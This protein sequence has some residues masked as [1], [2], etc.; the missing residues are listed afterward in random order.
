MNTK[1]LNFIKEMRDLTEESW[2][3][4][5]CHWEY[6]HQNEPRI[7]YRVWSGLSSGVSIEKETEEELID[8]FDLIRKLV[9]QLMEAKET[10]KRI[11]VKQLNHY[12]I[13]D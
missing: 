7:R 8:S 3:Y 12:P 10:K 11:D 4:E 13:G 1:I 5:T 9:G 2:L 6:N